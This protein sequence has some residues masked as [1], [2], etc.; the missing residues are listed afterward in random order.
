[1]KKGS[2][3][4]TNAFSYLGDAY[5]FGADVPKWDE[6]FRGATD[7]A[8][9]V[10]RT[11][12]LVTG[13]VYGCSSKDIRKAD[14]YTGFFNSDAN[15]RGTIISVEMAAKIPGAILL[16]IPQLKAVGINSIGHVVFSQ[17]NGMTVEAHS[18]KYGVI[19][20]KV[21]GRRWDIGILVPGIDYDVRNFV[22]TEA[23][24]IVFRLKA[25]MMK[26]EFVFKLQQALKIKADGYFGPQ[27]QKAVV[28][29]QKENGLIVDGEVM[30]EGETAKLLRI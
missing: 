29:F 28:K 17:G 21:D 8:E 2:D 23:P 7:C 9:F 25:P 4:I 30:P 12:Y 20:S 19:Q 22:F 6:N 10:A 26:D 1:M 15:K 3:L 5:K 16:R 13:I 27:T 14:A 24:K 11:I 18:T